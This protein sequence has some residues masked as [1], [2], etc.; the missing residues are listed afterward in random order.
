MDTIVSTVGSRES[1]HR[2]KSDTPIRVTDSSR[3]GKEKQGEGPFVHIDIPGDVKIIGHR[4]V[5]FTKPGRVVDS[6]SAG[7]EKH[8][9][10]GFDW[11]IEIQDDQGELPPAATLEPGNDE[12]EVVIHTSGVF[13]VTGASQDGL[14]LSVEG[15]EFK[16]FT[17]FLDGVAGQPSENSGAPL[18][19][20]YFEP[21]KDDVT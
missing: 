7:S 4:R 20:N 18:E 1:H 21:Q 16:R 13:I 11:R 19:I 17:V 3:P 6:C 8:P 14:V 9:L 15:R 5:L 12:S 10:R 2:G